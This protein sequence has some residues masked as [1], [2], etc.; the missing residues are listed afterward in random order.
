MNAPQEQS[1]DFSLDSWLDRLSAYTQKK[2][3][4]EESGVV[5]TPELAEA[6]IVEFEV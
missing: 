4:I 5:I 6:L 1:Q 3:E 2:R